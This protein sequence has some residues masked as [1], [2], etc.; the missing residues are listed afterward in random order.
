[1][2][3]QEELPDSMFLVELEGQEGATGTTLA[4]S[5][6][7]TVLLTFAANRFTRSASRLYHDRFGIGAMDWRMLVMLTREPGANVAK[8]S[9][10]I[11]IDKAAVSRSLTR[12]KEKGLAAP[13]Q[14]S[15][16]GRRKEWGLT[17]Q[18]RRLHAEILQVALNRQRHI[19][20]GF[21]QT[22][23]HAFNDYLKRFLENLE[24][25]PEEA[26]GQEE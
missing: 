18:G 16:S 24:D 15:P 22:E 1:M 9:A 5:R 6:A 12:L 21:S 25:L 13:L 2:T 23:V 26:L 14:S 7:T 4:F 8:A 10:T 19:L 11:G 17:E 20:K 3:H